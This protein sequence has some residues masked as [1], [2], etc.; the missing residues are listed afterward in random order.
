MSTFDIQRSKL[1]IAKLHSTKTSKTYN[2]LVFFINS[3][4]IC[5]ENYFLEQ[6]IIVNTNVN[7]SILVIDFPQIA[8]ADDF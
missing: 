8:W 1:A 7:I 5:C 3:R 6:K 2:Y 4:N